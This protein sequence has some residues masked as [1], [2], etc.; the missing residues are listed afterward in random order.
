MD[1][2]LKADSN[3]KHMLNVLHVEDNRTDQLVI[4]G[5]LGN[6]P[7]CRITTHQADTVQAAINI[8]GQF[9]FDIILL[10]LSLPDS[11]GL[12]T[13]RTI[14]KIAPYKPI[15]LL[16]GDNSENIIIE[17]ISH[18]AQDYLPKG[19][20]KPE[21]IKRTMLAAIHRKKIEDA[22][23]VSE[24]RFELAVKGASV[25]LWDW[26]IT[27]D[28]LYWSDKFKKIV[29][30]SNATFTP[31]I[32]AFEERLHPED[33]GHVMQAVHEHLEN[34]TE[35]DVEYRLQHQDG[36]Y[37]WIHARG[38]AIWDKNGKPT[39]MAGSVDDI[40][41][42]KQAEQTNL[43]MQLQLSH[44]QKL[45]SI[46]QL[47]AGIAH[48]I[49]TPTQF[50][51]DNTRFL[52]DA[53]DNISQLLNAYKAL[54]AAIGSEQPIDELI[55]NIKSTIEDI[56]LDYLLDEIPIAT[57]QALDG[58]GR[59][60]NIVKAMKEFSHPGSSKKEMI[61]I[62]KAIANTITV[63][64]N[65]WKYVAEIKTDFNPESLI[66]ECLP[67]EINQVILNIIVNAAHAI[68]D[69]ID[70]KKMEKGL[71]T[72]STE[73]LDNDCKITITD[74]GTGIP[75]E[76]LNRVFDPFFTT[77]DVGKGTGQGLAIAYSVITEKHQGSIHVDSRTG[78]GT[79]FTIRIP[80]R[81]PTESDNT[82]KGNGD[83]EKAAVC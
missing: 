5:I 74:T 53:F 8:I 17:G 16:T 48:E 63:S 28:Q 35:Y 79:T 34:H 69:K 2:P 3:I 54:T 10:D 31:Q 13:L 42:K 30:V 33:H 40:S 18:G 80:I 15:V 26:D 71:I 11:E 32:S 44:A 9:D 14:H 24:E 20:V 49:N 23:K 1:M 60:S 6:I 37:V 41:E 47:A 51:G 59:I 22:L 82:Q 81:S 43:A 72:L 75:E 27:N 25:G 4:K 67:G 62:N 68:A 65:E 66:V 76:I 64:S 56:D 36:H 83:E 70:T 61:D 12:D 19:T 52:Q 29:G 77:K 38:Q 57:Q 45:E 46:G 78:E 55:S 73:Q 7:D 58:V 21:L 39:R 50:V